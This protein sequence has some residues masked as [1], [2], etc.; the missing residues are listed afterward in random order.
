MED[1]QN[2]QL[3]P[4]PDEDFLDS[5]E[6]NVVSG[7]ECTGLIPTPPENETEAEAYTEL[8]AIPRPAK[9]KAELE[10]SGKQQKS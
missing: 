10:K 5:C 1:K 9:N 4:Q 2:K 6:N 3:A 8:Y 7:T